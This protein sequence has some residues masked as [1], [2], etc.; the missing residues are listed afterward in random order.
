LR[1]KNIRKSARTVVTMPLTMVP[2]PVTTAPTML[3]RPSWARATALSKASLIS[4]SPMFSGGPAAHSR[5]RWMPSTTPSVNSPDWDAT[6]T[7]ISATTPAATAR[8]PTVTTAAASAAGHPCRLR[9]RAKGQVRVVSSSPTRSGQTTDHI[10]PT[11]H[12]TTVSITRTSSNS[13]DT[14]ADVRSAA[15]VFPALNMAVTQAP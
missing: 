7:A 5:S 3:P 2:T 6:G 13:P 14:R 1:K 9:Y 4:A 8:N 10:R 15:R 12:R 11:T